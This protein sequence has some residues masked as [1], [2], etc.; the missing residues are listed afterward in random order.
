MNSRDKGKRGEREWAKVCREHGY[1]A[2]R[3]QQFCG[4]DGSADVVGIPG[5]HLE[6]KRVERLNIDNAME[7]SISDARDGEMP[8]VAH[9]KNGGTW[10]VTMTASDWFEVIEAFVGRGGKKNGER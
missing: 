3:G 4:A 9:R 1:E 5:V 6:V 10:L 8:V 7:Q 2:R